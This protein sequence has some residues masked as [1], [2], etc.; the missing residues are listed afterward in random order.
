MDAIDPAYGTTT[1]LLI[2]AAAVAVL[3]F[4]IIK[5]KLHAFVA[6]VLVSLLTALAAGIP[7]ADVPSALS[8]GFS[9]TLGSVALLVGFGVMIGRLLETTGGA[10]VLA[11]TLIG[12]FGEKRAPLALGVAALL[13]GFP[14]FFDAGLVVFLPIIMTV[15][16]R[17]GGS[18]LLYAFPA[19]GAFAAMHALVPP[20]PGPV[21]A[22]E[23]LGANIGLTLIVGVPVALV[24][25]YVG[26]FLVS[27]V[28][29][30]R[31]HV[32]IPTSLFGEINGGRDSDATGT[33]ADADGAGATGSSKTATRTTPSFLTVLGVLLLPFVLISCNT[34]VATLQ[35]AGV[36]PEEATWAEYL[37]LIGTTSIALLIT[38]IVAT[39]VL[40]L[41]G[42][43]MATVTDI[44]DNALGPICAII[45]ITGAGGMFGGVLRTSGIGDALSGSLS[46][47]GISLILQAF[48][49]ST[50]LRVA[51]GSATVALTTTAG[52]LSAAVA[53]AGLSS[54][55]L[56]ALVMAI[57]AGATVLSHVND[58]GFWLVS[59][60]FGM[61][62]K[63]TLK[64]WTLLETTLGLTAFVISLGLWA[65]G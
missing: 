4:L 34:V 33:E 17:F 60:F 12:R 57:A 65:M 14:I 29:G 25:W 43:S 64:T 39:L 16:R 10:Q 59:R 53:A 48:L 55:Q 22:A 42:R 62:V 54:L 20:H 47:L 21:A 56:T 35:T 6:L 19:A 24:S 23:L 27:Q 31:V 46:D 40:G 45:L 18:L 5:V 37:K 11:D 61:D 63:T 36:I 52:L 38:V 1:L 32:D 13:F 44:L 26:A 8:S 49:I 51:Q 3:L 7:V 30:R 28:I 2:A 15:A 41:R 58:S 9:S 50:L